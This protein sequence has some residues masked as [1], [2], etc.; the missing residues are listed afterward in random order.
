MLNAK[1]KDVAPFGNDFKSPLGVNT[2]ISLAYRFSLNCS[3]KSTAFA[4]GFSKAS[5]NFNPLV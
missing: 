3:I 5:C 4:S 2:K 1:S